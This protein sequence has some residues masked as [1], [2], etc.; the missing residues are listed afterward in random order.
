MSTPSNMIRPVGRLVEADDRPP[1][2]ASCRSPTRRRARASRPRRIAKRDA[3]DGAHVPDV[4]PEDDAVLDREPD[5]DVLDP[6]ERRHRQEAGRRQ[7]GSRTGSAATARS[8]RDSHPLLGRQGQPGGAGR[9]RDEPLVPGHD[10]RLV[11]PRGP[12]SRRTRPGGRRHPPAAARP[13]TRRGADAPRRPPRRSAGCGRRSGGSPPD[14]SSRP[15]RRAGRGQAGLSV[16][17]TAAAR[18]SGARTGNPSRARRWSGGAPSIG[19]SVSARSS[20]AHA[21]GSSGA[22]RPCTGATGRRTARGSWPV[23]TMRPAY[24]TLIRWVI[25]AT[26]PEVVGDQDQGG[27]RLLGQSAQDLQDLRLDRH[28]E[29]RRRLVGDHQPRLQRQRHRDHHALA[30]PAGEP[31]GVMPGLDPGIHAMP[32]QRTLLR[33]SVRCTRSWIAGS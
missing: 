2:R 6:Q 23:S 29:G 27:A 28:V 32:Q 19:M 3:V 25:P 14:R 13:R 9:G 17:H 7:A 21:A 11:P 18:R 1:D 16:Q 15:A 22:T 5:L 10:R 12:S 26:T 4:A 20:V 33:V 31:T 30:H 8:G 24:M